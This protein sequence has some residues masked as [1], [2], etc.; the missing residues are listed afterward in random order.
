[1]N[2]LNNAPGV[3]QTKN[4]IFTSARCSPAAFLR[5]ESFTNARSPEA[6]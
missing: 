2:I 3:Y 1:M 5:I 6:E 4:G